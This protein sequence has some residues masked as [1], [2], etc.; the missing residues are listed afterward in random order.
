MEREEFNSVEE[1]IAALNSVRNIDYSKVEEINDI[2]EREFYNSLMNNFRGTRNLRFTAEQRRNYQEALRRKGLLTYSRWKQRQPTIDDRVTWKDSVEKGSLDA[3]VN[4]FSK[5]V[6]T[7]DERKFEYIKTVATDDERS[8]IGKKWLDNSTNILKGLIE[9]SNNRGT[10][11]V[12]GDTKVM[13]N[14]QASA[15]QI[16]SDTQKDISD[17]VKGTIEEKNQQ[18]LRDDAKVN[19]I[20]SNSEKELSNFVSNILEDRKSQKDLGQTRKRG[21]TRKEE[22]DNFFTERHRN[23]RSH[24]EVIEALNSIPKVDFD[25]EP[26]KATQQR[27]YYNIM[28]TLED[29]SDLDIPNGSE[30]SDIAFQ[31]RQALGN[32]GCKT[33]KE[34]KASGTLN[35]S[36]KRPAKVIDSMLNSRRHDG[37]KGFRTAIGKVR[38]DD[39]LRDWTDDT[40][41]TLLDQDERRLEKLEKREKQREPV[42]VKRRRNERRE[43]SRYPV[44]VEKE[45]FSFKKLFKKVGVVASFLGIAGSGIAAAS[46]A[47]DIDDDLAKAEDQNKAKPGRIEKMKTNQDKDKIKENKKLED[48]LKDAGVDVQSFEDELRDSTNYVNGGYDYN[49]DY[50]YQAD[51]NF[52]GTPKSHSE[53]NTQANAKETQMRAEDDK[54]EQLAQ[55]AKEEVAD[56]ELEINLDNEIGDI[57]STDGDNVIKETVVV[58]DSGAEYESPTVITGEEGSAIEDNREEVDMGEISFGDEDFSEQLGEGEEE[59]QQQSIEDDDYTR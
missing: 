3:P 2:S 57:V 36:V 41:I 8:S 30:G 39:R 43:K 34:L 28:K 56:V 15:E 23:F 59:Q 42:L 32:I 25:N 1:A 13:Y 6:E 21:I 18:K 16:L 37:N 26:D 35:R 31:Y 29:A 19:E 55:E 47:L 14:R 20:M 12:S 48:N 33:M 24:D 11:S 46:G 22:F 45:K 27:F 9:R 58:D 7:D 17:F 54:A 53:E 51:Q 50:N 4:L 38:D 49:Y 44:P 10:K 52:A 40:K 5:L